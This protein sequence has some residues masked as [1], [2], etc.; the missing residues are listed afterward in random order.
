M[1]AA[2]ASTIENSNISSRLYRD[3]NKKAIPVVINSSD[4][5]NTR[6]QTLSDIM[7]KVIIILD[8]SVSQD[9]KSTQY[10]CANLSQPPTK[11]NNFDNYVNMLSGGS[12]PKYTYS[13]VL[14]Q[15]NTPPVVNDNGETVSLQYFK[16]VCPDT[17]NNFLGMASSPPYFKLPLNYGIQVVMYPF[18][19]NDINLGAYEEVFANSNGTA[20]V[21]MTSML[22]YIKTNIYHMK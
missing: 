22:S 5:A 6:G 20:F 19:L 10:A 7:G 3:G 16:M 2:I 17:C 18:Y 8:F 4:S 11:C 9:Y 15:K 1:Y 14:Q 12:N 21:P 13:N